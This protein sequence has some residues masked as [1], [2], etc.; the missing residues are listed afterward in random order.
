MRPNNNSG[1]WK[2]LGRFDAADR[3][4]A[5]LV[6][7]RAEELVAAL[8]NGGPA[9]GCPTLRLKEA[10]AKHTEAMRLVCAKRARRYAAEALAQNVKTLGIKLTAAQARALTVAATA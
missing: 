5:E 1:A 2:T 7:A 9:K 8:N 3:D 6:M 4:Q 10:V